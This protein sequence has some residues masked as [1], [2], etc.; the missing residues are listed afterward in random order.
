MLRV[1]PSE[2]LRLLAD[3]GDGSQH[4]DEG[5]P[6]QEGE[7]APFKDAAADDAVRVPSL[8]LLAAPDQFLAR[9]AITADTC[10][11]IYQRT[12]HNLLL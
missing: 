7:F 10:G 5:K 2:E 8:A 11:R 1:G 12:M 9:H 4:D 6:P 3:Q